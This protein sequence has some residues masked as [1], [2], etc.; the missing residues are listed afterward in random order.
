M[1]KLLV[2]LLVILAILGFTGVQSLASDVIYGCYNKSG[3]L[4]IAS[5]PGA[6]DKNN[7]TAISWNQAGPAGPQG[8]KGDPGAKGDPGPQ[9][10][11][12]PQGPKGEEGEPGLQ[13]PKG[14]KG[15]PGSAGGNLSVYDANGQY[16]G[17][18]A[19]MRYPFLQG[20][21]SDGTALDIFIPSLNAFATIKGIAD[22]EPGYIY[23]YGQVFFD[24]DDNAYVDTK[25]Y[26][27]R[28]YQCDRFYIGTGDP[29]S[30]VP[31][32]KSDP[33]TGCSVTANNETR[34]Y[35]FAAEEIRKE[36]LP[37]TF[38]IAWPIRIEYE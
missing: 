29:V 19:A 13:G 21:L 6:C 4:R 32:F 30:F 23:D 22:G 27:Y 8:P 2:G 20:S 31:K 36:D 24:E 25:H 28:R 26:L 38:P 17:I 37:L 16:L 34:P 35:Y 10:P 33:S 3:Q 7:E 11:A 18:V 1:K 5:G 12:G 14:D 9:G 15:E